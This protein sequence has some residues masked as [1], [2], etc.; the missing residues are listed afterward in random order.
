MSMTIE[1]A[2]ATLQANLGALAPRDLAFAGSLLDQ[3]TR[4][5]LSDKQAHWLVVLAERASKPADAPAAAPAAAAIDLSRI[6]A[7]FAKAGGARPA[8]VIA[9]EAAGKVRVSVAG[10][11]SREPGTIVVT[12]A[13]SFATRAYLGRIRLSGE[14]VMSGNA[15][16]MGIAQALTELLVAFAAD[17]AAVA[18]T[19]GAMTGAC[20]FCTKAL[21]DPVSVALGYGPVCADRWGL[22]HDLD[23]AEAANPAIAARSTRRRK[24]A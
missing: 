1:A 10:E 11:A 6:L 9:S 22:P 15:E 12:T 23:A 14:W 24:A 19:F 16:R 4:R 3:M 13:G 20:S 2:A 18:K 7:M 5:G 17:P 8:L 21:V